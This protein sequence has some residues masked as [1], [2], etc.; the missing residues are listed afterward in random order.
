VLAVEE[1][2][3]AG[4]EALAPDLVHFLRNLV[5]SPS[6]PNQEGDV[7]SLVADKLRQIG[8]D[9]AIVPTHFADLADHPAFNDDGFSPDSRINVVGRWP[10]NGQVG[11]QDGP[12]AH[13]SL[14]L[15]GHVD[16]VSPGDTALWTHDPWSGHIE[17]G[18]LYGRGSCDMKAGL[19]AGIFAL[20]TLR[21]LGYRPAHDLLM[22]SVIG[23]ESGGVGAL[24]TIV[25]GFRADAAIILE[26]TRQQ[27]C[28][29]Q[30]GALTFRITVSG[31]AAHGAMKSDGVSAIDKYL[32]IHAALNDLD[33]RRHRSYQNALYDNPHN[34]API[35]MGTIQGGEW[36][37]T[38]PERIRVEGRCGVFPGES[39]T[40]VR[41]LLS[42]TVRHAAAKDEWLKEHPPLVE[43]FEGQFEAAETPIEHPLIHTL[44]ANHRHVH[45]S[46][47]AI[48]GVPYGAD[49]RLY[50][51]HAAMPAVLYGPGDVALAHAVNEYVP[52]RD[53]IEVTKTVAMTIVSWC[54]G[55]LE[56]VP[57]ES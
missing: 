46:E 34:V 5:Q 11:S 14:L 22:T 13:G 24:T 28:P 35:S 9:V 2:I 15:N 49:M 29:V 6:L 19:T 33:R 1:A 43:W 10:G 56:G 54:G 51:N 20:A 57:H 30:A 41:N 17:E 3:D 8:L 50:T 18:K 45:G 53:V 4:V 47:P 48:K 55:K 21:S 26:P 52:L 31:K 25:K 36:H 12:P 44:T 38:V 27:I 16:V 40:E 42:K 37:S 23:E 32:P 39:T 7:Q